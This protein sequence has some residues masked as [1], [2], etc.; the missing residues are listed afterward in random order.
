MRDSPLPRDERGVDPEMGSI[1]YATHRNTASLIVGVPV[2]SASDVAQVAGP[3]IGGGR[4]REL[5][6]RPPEAGVANAA[7]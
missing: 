3:G 5:C 7:V 6:R 2:Y 4:E 1:P